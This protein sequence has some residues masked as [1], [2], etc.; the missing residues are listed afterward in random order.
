MTKKINSQVNPVQ[1]SNLLNYCFR[2]FGDVLLQSKSQL[3]HRTSNLPSQPLSTSILHNLILHKMYPPL[4]CSGKSWIF[5]KD[6]DSF[7]KPFDL[8]FLFSHT[9]CM[10]VTGECHFQNSTLSSSHK[11][12]PYFDIYDFY[13]FHSLLLLLIN[14][15]YLQQSHW[16]LWNLKNNLL[17]QFDLGNSEWY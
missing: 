4:P 2:L 10:P 9:T 12:P 5:S 3:I 7:L 6:N 16:G 13:F 1:I 11:N 15:I 8:D 14:I 17:L